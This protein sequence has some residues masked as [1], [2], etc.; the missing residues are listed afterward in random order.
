MLVTPSDAAGEIRRE[1]KAVERISGEYAEA[2]RHSLLVALRK[3]E[4][5][6]ESLAGGFVRPFAVT[7]IIRVWARSP[8]VLRDRVRAVQQA[9]HGMDGAHYLECTLPTTA[10]KLFFASWPGSIAMG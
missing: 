6:I 4:R 2:R 5:K 9:I 1:E 7:Y 8:E 3:K 10:K